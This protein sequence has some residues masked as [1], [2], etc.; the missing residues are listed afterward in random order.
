MFFEE[1]LQEIKVVSGIDFKI[2]K[3]NSEIPEFCPE[4]KGDCELAE[5]IKKD[6]DISIV[7]KFVCSLKKQIVIGN[8]IKLPYKYTFLAEKKKNISLKKYQSV[9]AILEKMVKHEKSDIEPIL[10]KLNVKGVSQNLK[11]KMERIIK[12]LEIFYK[13][14][15]LL[16]S[17]IDSGELFSLAIDL[18]PE[19]MNV[20]NCSL[21]LIDKNSKTLKIAAAKGISEKLIRKIE[22]QIGEGISGY[23]AKH[24]KPVLID[25]ISKNNQFKRSGSDYKTQ[26][27]LSVPL[28]VG[29]EIIGVINVNNK[30]YGEK[31]L[32]EDVEL[33]LALS[34]QLANYIEKAELLRKTKFQL[35]MLT[36]IHEVGKS[37]SSTLDMDKVLKLIMNEIIIL[38]QAE[39]G[40]I[41]LFE[42]GK[43]RIKASHGLSKKVSSN[44]VLKSGEGVAG[45]VAKFAKP[46]IILD[47]KKSKY[48]I[49]TPDDKHSDSMI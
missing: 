37:I 3:K 45:Y 29:T 26:S 34:G 6:Q 25:D 41:L 23:V 44:F 47:T 22:I 4:C 49:D 30:L 9:I 18:V 16:G 10:K 2:F 15:K 7:K 5:L 42:K 35:N 43:L 14:S 8:I 39:R 19:V 12:E 21:M 40:S 28:K 24:G 1:I 38:T 27:A 17:V 36:S 33:L 31:F 32:T 13:V 20:E 48:F 46:M 11:K